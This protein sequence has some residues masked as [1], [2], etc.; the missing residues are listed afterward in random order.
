MSTQ[1]KVSLALAAE[2]DKLDADIGL[3]SDARASLATAKAENLRNLRK[4][5]QKK[6]F[7]HKRSGFKSL[8]RLASLLP[9]ATVARLAK[10][11]FGP[12]LSG[13]IVG[14]MHP[15]TAA[16]IAKRLEPEFLAQIAAEA[17]PEHARKIIKLIDADVIRD[18]AMVL[19]ERQDYMLMGRF[20]DALS[21]PAI[22]LVVSAIK[23]DG[24]LLKI[25][26]YMEERSQLSKIVMMI[27]N[28]RIASIMRTGTQQSL[29]PQ[30]LSVIDNVN[31]ELRARLANIMAEQDEASL[32]N[33]VTVVH[34]QCL[35]A[36]VLRGVT[37][38]NP[39]YHRKIVNLP[40]LKSAEVL[41]DLVRDAHEEG[42][43]ASALPLAKV[44]RPEFQ[45]IIANA[46]LDQG[47]EVAEA[48]LWAAQNSGRW[49]VMLD[50]FQYLSEE[51]RDLVASLP[52]AQNRQVL[53]SL[54][55]SAAQS[56]KLGL[57][58]DFAKRIN[59]DGLRTVVDIGLADSG[60]LLENIL[61]VADKTQGGWKAVAIAVAAVEDDN[62]LKDVGEVYRR[63]AE[64]TRAAFRQA[65]TTQ[66]IWDRVGR[67]LEAA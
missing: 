16:K 45:E 55:Q 14:A 31:P 48:A 19:V 49:D 30:A 18:A 51:N 9:V 8:A 64:P 44:M 11:A 35:W 29:W 54:L 21:A 50:L 5:L 60:G 3:S 40:K 6:R 23:D 38:M 43:L 34:E 53:K 41:G 32:D 20:A 56:G 33:L 39:K 13:R 4:A 7:D 62:M 36:P 27:D 63:Q 17:E 28:D 26:Y 24:V 46:A 1:S 25:A 2:I 67:I 59:A 61:D 47:A 37:S 22:R 57:V 58:L 15:V 66:G 42:L 65:A 12:V 10:D 52:I